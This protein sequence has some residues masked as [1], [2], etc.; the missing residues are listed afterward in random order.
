LLA[1][2]M[3]SAGVAHQV[4][5]TSYVSPLRSQGGEPP[6]GRAAVRIGLPPP[7]DESV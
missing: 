4:V 3:L 6:P 1:E 2:A 5:S 7:M